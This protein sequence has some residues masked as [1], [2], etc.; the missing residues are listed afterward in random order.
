MGYPDG[1]LSQ[2]PSGT[3]VPPGMTC[4][5]QGCTTQTCEAMVRASSSQ[6]S[7]FKYAK[8]IQVRKSWH[9]RA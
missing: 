2:C 1:G 7:E 3:E 4:N 5:L 9:S 8:N 6:A